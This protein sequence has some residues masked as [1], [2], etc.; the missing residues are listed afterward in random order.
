MKVVGTNKAGRQ[1]RLT[2]KVTIRQDGCIDVPAFS[3]NIF[4]C[5][6]PSHLPL[7]P[8]EGWAEMAA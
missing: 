8:S 1:T 4:Q 2:G 5:F 3:A 6:S 7:G